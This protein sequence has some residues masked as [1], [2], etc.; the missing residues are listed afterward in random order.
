MT[1]FLTSI[2]TWTLQLLLL[3]CITKKLVM[4]F[5]YNAPKL[6][7]LFLICLVCCINKGFCKAKVSVEFITPGPA[8][9]VEVDMPIGNDFS[10]DNPTYYTVANGKFNFEVYVTRATLL[11][12]KT[13]FKRIFLVV[14]PTDNIKIKILQTFDKYKVL[15]FEG[16][17]AEG[18][19]W[20]NVYNDQP[21]ANR[22]GHTELFTALSA[23]SK[24]IGLEKL[25]KFVGR[26]TG[27]LTALY[28]QGKINRQFYTIVKNEIR[29]MHAKFTIE[30]IKNLQDKISDRNDI[31]K[32][33][34]MVNAL[35]AF[36][37]PNNVENVH[38]MFS[39]SFLKDYY[40]TLAESKGKETSPEWGPYY[41]YTL[42]P[43]SIQMHLLGS[44]LVF[45]KMVGTSEFNS[46]KAYGLYKKE[47]PPN[48]YTIFL[49]TVNSKKQLNKPTGK[50][51]LDTATNYKTFADV[52]R[53]YKG[54]AVYIDL[55]ASWCMPCRGEFPHYK[56][57]WPIFGKKNITPVY[58]SIDRPA[59]KKVWQTL[60]NFNHL[61]GDHILVNK[62]LMKDIAATIYK[63][64]DISIPR[65]ILIDK[66]GRVISWDAP[67]PSDS[68]ILQMLAKM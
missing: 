59:A 44:T 47:F 60:I 48:A 35:L 65:Y 39:Q 66:N 15:S 7:L 42:A 23:K 51:R 41:A 55:W 20:Y 6:K 8:Q 67:R 58:I 27:P 61:E 24:D 18:Q 38:G 36:A 68:G 50:V 62:S 49:D 34:V 56:N 1:V 10:F 5:Y 32:Y 31:Q 25:G 3:D 46:K 43:D 33:Q 57:L 63:N 2:T 53:H 40:A 12:I 17:N 28:K 45:A 54:R 26:Q 14:G 52:Q 22:I 21:L 64:G 9:L 16:A 19:Y 29:A 37:G 13:S 11:Q 30:R 4:I